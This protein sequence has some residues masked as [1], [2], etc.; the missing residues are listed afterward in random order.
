MSH[1][2][3]NLRKQLRKQLR[4]KRRALTP[5]QQQQAAQQVVKKLR[6]HPVFLRSK[7]I[8]LYIADDGEIDMHYVIRAAEEMGKWCYLPILH[9]LKKNTLWFGRYCSGDAL[10]ANRFGLAEPYSDVKIFPAWALDLVLMPLVGFDRKGNRLGM[11]GGFYDRTFSFKSKFTE[12]ARCPVLM[13]VAHQ[14]QEVT[15]LQGESWDVVLDYIATDKE[16]I[17]AS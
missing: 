5:S 4:V 11:G 6:A 12:R 17:T 3:A 1:S 16:I 9:P 15:E 14:C 10:L 8:S 2:V 7:H 13:G